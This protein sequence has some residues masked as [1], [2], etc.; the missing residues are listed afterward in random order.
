ML[1]PVGPFFGDADSHWDTDIGLSFTGTIG[2]MC[3]AD[4]E[5]KLTFPVVDDLK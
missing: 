3:M 5:K 4:L 2:K 1:R